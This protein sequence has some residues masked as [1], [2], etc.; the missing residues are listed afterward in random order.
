M[1]AGKWRSFIRLQH[2]LKRERQLAPSI[3]LTN[4][5]DGRMATEVDGPS[6]ISLPFLP[7]RFYASRPSVQASLRLAPLGLDRTRP[8]CHR[9]RLQ[10]GMAGSVCQTF[11]LFLDSAGLLME[12]LIS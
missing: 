1:A 9:I 7:S 8:R 4:S 10:E 5:A 12:G 3:K 2:L 6:A 11:K